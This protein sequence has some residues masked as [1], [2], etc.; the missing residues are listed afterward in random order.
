MHEKLKKF[1][2]KIINRVGRIKC[3][4]RSEP[5][6]G[7]SPPKPRKSDPPVLHYPFINQNL[8]E[9]RGETGVGQVNP[10]RA[11]ELIEH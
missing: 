2:V 11:Y 1:S 10:S 9:N 3:G 7:K 8:I 4:C 5:D 6:L